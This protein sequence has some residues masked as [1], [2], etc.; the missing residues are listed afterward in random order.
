MVAKGWK[1]EY[2]EKG[3]G[4]RREE[5]GRGTWKDRESFES[6]MFYMGDMV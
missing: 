1:G 3:E 5:K 6:G 4:R 2:E